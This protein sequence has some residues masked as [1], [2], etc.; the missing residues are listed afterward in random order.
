MKYYY[1]VGVSV[2]EE[3]ARIECIEKLGT[4]K[5]SDAIRAQKA[6]KKA[7]DRGAWDHLKCNE[8]DKLLATVEVHDDKTFELIEILE[9]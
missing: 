5:K 9:I 7:I 4:N 1:S 6:L 3:N 8:S 2:E